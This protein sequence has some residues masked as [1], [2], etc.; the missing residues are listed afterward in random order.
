MEIYPTQN[1]HA[2][3]IIKKGNKKLTIPSIELGSCLIDGNNS[4]VTTASLRDIVIVHIISN[5]L[6]FNKCNNKFC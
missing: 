2:S 6:I 1:K 4:S 5:Q 3:D